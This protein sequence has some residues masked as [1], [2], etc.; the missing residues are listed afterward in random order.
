MISSPGF[1]VPK[2]KALIKLLLLHR[3]RSHYADRLRGEIWQSRGGINVVDSG[4][5][6]VGVLR[7]C[8]NGSDVLTAVQMRENV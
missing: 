4:F 6:S 2:V 8:E 7:R 5:Y 1:N 3:N